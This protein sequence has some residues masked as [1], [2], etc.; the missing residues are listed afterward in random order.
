MQPTEFPAYRKLANARSFYRIDSHTE[1][2]EVQ[3]VGGRCVAHR[4]VAH[5]YP[6]K[7][8]ISELLN[9]TDGTVLPMLAAEFEAW[10]AKVG[11]RV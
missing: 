10:F 1:F 11:P 9:G 2:T 5:N 4:V 8:R 7:V 6:E 3:R